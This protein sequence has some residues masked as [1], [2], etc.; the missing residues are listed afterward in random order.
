MN[1]GDSQ[2][3]LAH[4]IVLLS[5]RKCCGR[6]RAEPSVPFYFFKITHC[7]NMNFISSHT[8]VRKYFYFLNQIKSNS[9]PC[10]TIRIK[11]PLFA[12]AS[13]GSQRVGLRWRR[14]YVGP[15]N[16]GMASYL[17]TLWSPMRVPPSRSVL[18]HVRTEGPA[19]FMPDSGNR[20][21]A[22]TG[23]KALTPG[24]SFPRCPA[25]PF[26]SKPLAWPGHCRVPS[27]L[28]PGPQSLP[29]PRTSNLC[30]YSPSLSFDFLNSGSVQHQI[31]SGALRK[32]IFASFQGPLV[33]GNAG[34]SQLLLPLFCFRCLV[35]CTLTQVQNIY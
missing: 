35:S 24:A 21:F 25:R 7:K 16:G 22:K 23:M 17:Q 18:V 4:P 2:L 31:P 5:L 34:T 28:F 8:N 26:L 33:E 12:L 32:I 10:L 30:L 27:S 6:S 15:G 13:V 1:S 29:L 11:N 19:P 9:E 3:H 14:C 20:I